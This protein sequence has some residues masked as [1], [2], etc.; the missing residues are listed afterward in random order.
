MYETYVTVTGVV[1]TQPRVVILDDSLRITS[2]RLASTSR[3]RDRDGNWSDGHTTWLTVTCWRALAANV[4]E[5]VDKKDRVVVHGRLRT[6]DWTS[7][8]GQQRTT[9]EVEADAVGHDLSFGTAAFTRAHRV[10]PV[11][12]PGRADAEDL[13]RQVELDA[14]EEDLADLVDGDLGGGEPEQRGRALPAMTA[15][16]R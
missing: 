9:I 13:V 4:A 14:A 8:E 10:E 5:S 15:A 3:R 6:R 2:F 7:A 16:G 11:E 12:P 1:A